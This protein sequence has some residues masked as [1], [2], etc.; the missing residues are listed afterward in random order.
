MPTSGATTRRDTVPGSIRSSPVKELESFLD[1][2]TALFVGVTTGKFLSRHPRLPR[3]S[4]T[5]SHIEAGSYSS[6]VSLVFRNRTVFGLSPV[7]N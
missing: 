3:F 5:R 1:L 7:Q 2:R 4:E 6:Q